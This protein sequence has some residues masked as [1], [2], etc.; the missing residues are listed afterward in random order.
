MLSRLR[1]ARLVWPT[2]LSISALILLIALGN[3]QMSRKAWKERLIAQIQAGLTA[4]PVDIGPELRGWAAPSVAAEYRRIKVAGRF[5]H[6]QE[7][8]LYALGPE[9]PGWHV[10]TPMVLGDGDVVLVNRG[11][12]PDALKQPSSRPEGQIAGRVEVTGLLRLPETKATFTPV[13]DPARNIWFWRDVPAMLRCDPRAA[14]AGNDCGP[15]TGRETPGDGRPKAG[16]YPFVVDAQANP[17][18]PGGW[19]RGGATNFNIPN[20]HLEYA[21]TWY[22]LAVTLVVMYAAFAAS[23]W[24]RAEKSISASKA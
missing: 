16:V 15:L 14:A 17:A 13:N 11:Y 22:G 24:R 2:V 9:G 23:R 5:L 10:I 8:H 7:R 12:V 1:T 19:P 6:G 20:R 4:A 3:W 18:N 21:L